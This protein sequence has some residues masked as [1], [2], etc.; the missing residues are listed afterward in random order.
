[1]FPLSR[2]ATP[3]C[4]LR[5]GG[6]GHKVLDLV[7]RLK[8]INQRLEAQDLENIPDKPTCRAS[9]AEWP[10]LRSGL[11]HFAEHRSLIRLGQ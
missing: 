11:G 4:Y 8:A 2:S 7:V 9:H 1:M 6:C 10:D 3:A 5:H